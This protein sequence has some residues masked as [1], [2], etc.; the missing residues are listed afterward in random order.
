MVHRAHAPTSARAAWAAGNGVPTAAAEGAIDPKVRT[1]D[2][3]M[4]IL[5]SWLQLLVVTSLNAAHQ[6]LKEE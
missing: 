4:I 6:F 5:L 2:M 1:S 3:R